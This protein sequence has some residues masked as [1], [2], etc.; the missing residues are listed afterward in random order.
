[1][2][3]KVSVWLDPCAQT[4][5][6]TSAGPSVRSTAPAGGVRSGQSQ[7]ELRPQQVRSY[8]WF[9]PQNPRMRTTLA[10]AR[11]RSGSEVWVL[12]GPRSCAEA[13][14]FRQLLLYSTLAHIRGREDES[15]CSPQGG[16]V[17]RIA[18]NA[19]A[20]IPTR[21]HGQLDAAPRAVP[22]DISDRQAR[23]TKGPQCRQQEHRHP[24]GV[25][26]KGSSRRSLSPRVLVPDDE[27]GFLRYAPEQRVI[28]GDRR[29][30][31]GIR[32]RGASSRRF[33]R[34]R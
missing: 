28:V 29:V 18:N 25:D 34:A 13:R 31:C 27:T 7:Q 16:L 20:A 9:P 6:F 15:V 19:H 1:M 30:I 2:G 26:P 21:P 12:Q 24:V 10:G 5:R 8:A 32:Q 4:P 33:S 11:G 23:I 14:D 17:D 22:V 3:M